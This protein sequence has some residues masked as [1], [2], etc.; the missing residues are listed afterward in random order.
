M[1]SIWSKITLAFFA[2]M[3]VVSLASCGGKAPGKGDV[4]RCEEE[5][6]GAVYISELRFVSDEAVEFWQTDYIPGI[7]EDKKDKFEK[8]GTA[9]Y[10]INKKDLSITLKLEGADKSEVVH[11]SEDLSTITETIDGTDVVYKKVESKK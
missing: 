11:Y 1:K 3:M 9:T 7:S 2:V 6:Y 5:A 10:K 8:V 4:Y